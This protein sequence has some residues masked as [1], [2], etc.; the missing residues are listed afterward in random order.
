[1][2]KERIVYWVNTKNFPI[3]E[4]AS[5][6]KEL[7]MQER[8][9]VSTRFAC[10]SVQDMGTDPMEKMTADASTSTDDLQYITENDDYYANILVDMNTNMTSTFEPIMLLDDLQTQQ[11]YE[12]IQTQQQQYE[13]IQTQQQQ[14]EQIQTQQQFEQYQTQ[15]QY[16]LLQYEQLQKQQFELQYDNQFQQFQLFQQ[17]QLDVQHLW[18]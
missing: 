6:Y 17:L 12:Q 13:Q 1:M 2:G 14:Y 3:F 9:K 11:Q 10:M 8:Q 7:T 4:N 18:K 16:E 5:E 15:Q